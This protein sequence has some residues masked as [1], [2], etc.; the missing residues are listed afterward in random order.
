MVASLQELLAAQC[1]ARPD[2]VALTYGDTD[3][4]WHELNLRAR[5]VAAALLDH[6]LPRQ[7]RVAFLGRNC[8]WYFDALFGAA[9]ADAIFVPL[10][11]RLAPRE[12]AEILGDTAAPVVIVQAG[13]EELIE[14]VRPLLRQP[15][16]IVLAGA[17]DGP[18]GPLALDTWAPPTDS[19][20]GIRPTAADHIAFQLYTS[21]TTGRPK[22]AMF[23]NGTNVKALLDLI[24]VQW[25]LHEDDVSLATL[26]LFHMGGLAWVLASMAR[27]ARIV[28]V[29]F[30]PGP[31]LDACETHG[32]TT[33]FFV[34]A[35]LT[36]LMAAAHDAGRKLAIRRL[37]Y[38][39][40]PI[41]P[42]ILSKAIEQFGCGFA[43][44]YGMTEATGAFAQLDPVDH[45][46][47]G[48][49]EH[50]L[51]S[52]GRAYPWAEV[53]VANPQSGE[54]VA[55]GGIG[56]IW[57]RSEQNMRGYFDRPEEMAATIT[58][59]GWL[60][61]GDIGYLD[62]DGYLFLLDRK[63]DV[64]ISGGENVYP[65]EVENVLAEHPAVAEV[66]VVGAPDPQWGETVVAVI[67]ARPDAE[68]DVDEVIAF[69]RQRLAGFKIPRRVELRA[70]LPRT[71]TGKV[72][73]TILR[74]S[75]WSGYDRR[76]N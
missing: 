15:C 10:N 75:F 7:T 31:V 64:I 76:I 51:R 71:A 16:E 5:G 4:T 18:V 46:P 68:L 8:P 1:A 44:I 72:R 33:T 36:S 38:S 67:V 9:L 65:V 62:E 49:R 61:T 20:R 25:D 2:R 59:D 39:G 69:A 35:M 34:P 47:G 28:L 24:S 27:G 48:P 66:A 43:Q 11:W 14:Q 23:A 17:T 30:E 73:K 12:L 63:K 6:G 42:S 60:R 40:A 53:R 13:L 41:S 52:A 22:G 3:L 57:T 50:L 54:A 58:A 19:D 32:V 26:P 55:H 29:D 56:E 70:T 45:D 37:M 74:E 21:G